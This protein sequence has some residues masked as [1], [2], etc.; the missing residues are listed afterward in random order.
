MGLTGGC[1]TFRPF[2]SFH[3]VAESICRAS[4]KAATRLRDDL[5]ELFL[6]HFR[7]AQLFHLF[8]VG[9]AWSRDV[10]RARHTQNHTAICPDRKRP[11]QVC[12]SDRLG[13]S[14]C[15][16][17]FAWHNFVRRQIRPRQVGVASQCGARLAV[18][19]KANFGDFG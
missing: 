8:L 5:S 6:T 15:A 16:T 9:G 4:G 17:H 18:D 19:Q 14:C 11:R 13:R 10:D 12:Q 2:P 3:R 1:G 7:Y